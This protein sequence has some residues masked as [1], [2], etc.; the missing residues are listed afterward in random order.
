MNCR[1]PDIDDG[2]AAAAYVR[3]HVHSR[4][5]LRHYTLRNSS[6]RSP[7]TS[8]SGRRFPQFL[9]NLNSSTVSHPHCWPLTILVIHRNITAVAPHPVTQLGASRDR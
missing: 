6:D 1:D 9:Y 2:A 5:E 4:G 3:L 7:Q 8:R